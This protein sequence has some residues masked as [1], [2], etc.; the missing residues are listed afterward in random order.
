MSRRP[1][2]RK[3]IEAHLPP[4][5]TEQRRSLIGQIAEEN[6]LADAL[7][8]ACLPDER[9]GYGFC[10]FVQTRRRHRV[11]LWD[12]SE[13]WQR[14]YQQRGTDAKIRLRRYFC[15]LAQALRNENPRAYKD[16]QGEMH[17]DNIPEEYATA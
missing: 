1:H 4:E 9:R 17:Y 7:G 16:A 13:G 14:I 10:Y 8:F 11:V 15:T 2:W 6:D 5:D 12:T 3:T